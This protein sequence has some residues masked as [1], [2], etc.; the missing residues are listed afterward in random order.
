M[1]IVDGLKREQKEI[2]EHLIN[3]M[4]HMRGSLSRN[5]AWVLSPQERTDILKYIED[6]IKIVEK[7]KLPLL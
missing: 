2:R 7:T 6:R 3:L 1:K 4:W 5:E